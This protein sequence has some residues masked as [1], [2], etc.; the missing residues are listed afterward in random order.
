MENSNL[1]NFSKILKVSVLLAT[2]LVIALLQ[3]GFHSKRT[4]PTDEHVFN[5]KLK[6]NSIGDFQEMVLAKAQREYF[7]K[8]IVNKTFEGTWKNKSS[9]SKTN[10][11][12]FQ[13]GK[14][15]TTFK[16]L[17]DVFS[18]RESMYF[19]FKALAGETIDDFIISSFDTVPIKYVYNEETKLMHNSSLIGVMI[20]GSIF[21]A[22]DEKS[23]FL[24]RLHRFVGYKGGGR[25]S[26]RFF[27]FHRL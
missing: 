5:R 3:R 17:L 9:L 1:S 18:E 22:R 11:F 21:E 15:F 20:V 14:F 27:F 8:D 4:K 16:T 19:N 2:L 24:K 23:I 13:E 10:L 26:K 7:F 6:Q 25:N 12:P